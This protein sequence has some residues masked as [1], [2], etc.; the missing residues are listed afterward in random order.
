MIDI[1]LFQSCIPKEVHNRASRLYWIDKANPLLSWYYRRPGD[2]DKS[3]NV[4]PDKMQAKAHEMIDI[5]WDWSKGDWQLKPF[6]LVASMVWRNYL[7]AL[8]KFAPHSFL[9]ERV[10]ISMAME[11][12][13]RY[14]LPQQEKSQA[15]RT[16]K[17]HHISV[18]AV[19]FGH[20]DGTKEIRWMV[21]A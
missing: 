12:F 3:G 11:R 20:Q 21:Q 8:S 1:E 16:L 19:S 17:A 15:P 6:R 4:S 9:P 10:Q 14:G 5:Y 2:A 7:A 13:I 18:M